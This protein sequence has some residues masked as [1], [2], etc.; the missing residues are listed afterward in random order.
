MAYSGAF[1]EL[2]ISVCGRKP[3]ITTWRKLM[4]ILINDI[5]ENQLN[6]EAMGAVIGGS[7]IAVNIDQSH[8]VDPYSVNIDNSHYVDPYSVNIDNSHYVDPYSVNIDNSH[9]VDPY[10]VN[11]DNSH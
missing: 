2:V 1:L 8:H 10:S 9:Y 3:R 6:S 7:M 4:G 11:I 5:Q